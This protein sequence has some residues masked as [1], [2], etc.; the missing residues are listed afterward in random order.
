[1]GIQIFMSSEHVHS[2]AVKPLKTQMQAVKDSDI[3]VFDESM[4]ERIRDVRAR[5]WKAVFETHVLQLQVLVMRTIKT[6]RTPAA[7]VPTVLA[8]FH[9]NHKKDAMKVLPQPLVQYLREKA[10]V[11][12]EEEQESA[13][14]AI[15]DGAETPTVDDLEL[16]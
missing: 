4:Q 10:Y 11:A 6:S 8:Q 16:L 1:M 9:T 15:V 13:L 7:R 2:Q 14:V 12:E 3:L 5:G